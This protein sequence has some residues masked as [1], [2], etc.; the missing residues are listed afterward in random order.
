MNKKEVVII[1]LFFLLVIPFI[2]L[3]NSHV[4]SDVIAGCTSG[5]QPSGCD[6]IILTHSDVLQDTDKNTVN[7]TIN[8][9]LVARPKNSSGCVGFASDLSNAV[10]SSPSSEPSC[11]GC[12]TMVVNPNSQTI[13]LNNNRDFFVKITI[14]SGATPGKYNLIFFVTADGAA[15]RKVNITGV[16]VSSSGCTS[17]LQCDDGNACT[18]DACSAGTCSHTQK[19]ES[20]SC[21][22]GVICCGGTCRAP[23]CTTGSCTATSTC[24][25]T[26]T[27]NNAGTCSA[28]CSYSNA[29]DL[30][31]CGSGKC[32][33]GTCDTSLT[34]PSNL[35]ISCSKEGCSTS[36]WIYVSDTSKNGVLCS[37][38]QCL[39]CNTVGSCSYQ[40]NS[41]CSQG[42]TCNSAGTCV[43]SGCT[44]DSSCSGSTP[45]CN[46][47]SG[48]CV[49]CTQ[50]TH[51]DD[52][53]V[54]TT[55]TCSAGTC[56]HTNNAIVCGGTCLQCSSG[57]C[58]Y[59]NNSKCSQGYTCNSAGTCVATCTPKPSCT[60]GQCG[61]WNNG[62][63]PTGTLN[64]GTCTGGQTC[65][66]TTNG[67]CCTPKTS[68]NAGE[69]GSYDNGTC[70]GT[71][72]CANNCGTG[73]FCLSGT[74]CTPATCSANH[75]G[76]CGT[77]QNGSCSGT[78]N[79]VN[80]CGTNQVCNSGTCCTP[81]CVGKT[82]GP[83]GCG[84]TCS[85][86]CTSLLYTCDN[87]GN[88]VL[89]TPDQLRGYLSVS[90][91]KGSYYEG[92]LISLS[93]ATGGTLPNLSFWQKLWEDIKH[94]FGI[95]GKAISNFADSDELSLINNTGDIP[96]QGTV[97]IKILNS[98]GQDYAIVFNETTSRTINS[99][100]YL[101]LKSL[102]PG[103]SVN[104][105]GTYKIYAEFRNS[106]GV[107]QTINGPLN[108]SFTFQV[109]KYF[110]GSTTDLSSSSGPI[111]GLTF[112]RISYGKI[113]FKDSVDITR[114]KNNPS[115]LFGNISITDKKIGIDTSTL[116]ELNGK[117]ATIWFRNISYTNPK[118]L[119]NGADCQSN[120][121]SSIDYNKAASTLELN[122]THF[123]SFEVVE[124]SSCGDGSCNNGETCS[125]CFG[126][127]GSCN[128]GGGNNGGGGTTTCISP[129][130]NCTFGPCSNGN[131]DEICV[132]LNK[133]KLNYKKSNRSCSIES[134]CIDN[135]K[136]G[137]GV[138]PDCLGTDLDDNNPN[139]TDILISPNPNPN[140]TKDNTWIYILVGVIVV[141]VILVLIFTFFNF[142]KPKAS[143]LSTKGAKAPP[144][145]T[146]IVRPNI[147]QNISPAAPSEKQVQ[148]QAEKQETQTNQQRQ[149]SDQTKK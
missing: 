141:I 133:C 60:T 64:C 99:K 1:A 55:D 36:S 118:I 123:S 6:P 134:N 59:Q 126:D 41:K 79:C 136:D 48:Q 42:Y 4:C 50:Q 44:S 131:Q 15:A 92:E 137:Y 104:T 32:C 116:S 107:I 40:N 10:V 16:V 72:N 147:P 149:N 35:N 62:T 17:D 74:C 89:I 87:S 120:I 98:A 83:D 81:N 46:T 127:C 97:L 33:Y 113:V 54:C 26:G 103:Y 73:Q 51:C 109:N 21:G 122:V 61:T 105:A 71:I 39:Q 135:D 66:S 148:A 117:P 68:C 45:H 145:Q 130:W 56:S 20:T 91:E 14:N 13:P 129:V 27:C 3:V 69:C 111:S 7:L 38:T 70:S 140:P 49:Q 24:K 30:T 11:S 139:I 96:L 143:V 31:V 146:P 94:L 90:T 58:S 53:K 84:G 78:I 43:A 125:S 88:C 5:C 114:F 65:N 25:P 63:C 57:S 144:G 121:C 2:P 18:T 8:F 85:P 67:V 142:K 110:D 29:P 124:G 77:Y 28:S 34:N 95:T 101:G 108:N 102:W 23:T 138:G 82:C 22:S 80:N 52:S 132:D 47:T 19:P 86:G 119:S 12:F 112:E 106:S 9:A 75:L 93:E 128:N 100:T 76:Q 37:G 115:I